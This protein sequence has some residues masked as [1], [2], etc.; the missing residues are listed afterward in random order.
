MIAFADNPLRAVQLRLT[1][2]VVWN[3]LQSRY[4]G[5]SV[6]NKRRDLD[7][8]L[9]AEQRKSDGMGDHMEDLEF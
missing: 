6:V 3:K 4:A 1:A 8:F 7:T 2:N 9:N 5:Q